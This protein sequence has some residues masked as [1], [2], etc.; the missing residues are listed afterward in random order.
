MFSSAGSSNPS[1]SIIS[2][3]SS[4]GN[5]TFMR[6]RSAFAPSVESPA[7]ATEDPYARAVRLVG[8]MTQD[9]KF[10]LIQQSGTVHHTAGYTGCLPAVPRLGIPETRMNDGP[11]VSDAARAMRV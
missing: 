3:C 8:L 4:V 11:Q 1:F 5:A 2:V 7:A 6:T 9:E 10:G